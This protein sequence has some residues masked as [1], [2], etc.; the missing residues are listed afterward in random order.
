MKKLKR[1]NTDIELARALARDY[2]RL[3]KK[4]FSVRRKRRK[5]K[6]PETQEG[7]IVG[8]IE[9]EIKGYEN[10]QDVRL[11]RGLVL[12]PLPKLT[13]TKT[14]VGYEDARF[15]AENAMR[16]IYASTAASGTGFEADHPESVLLEVFFQ[17]RNGLIQADS[18]KILELLQYAQQVGKP[19]PTCSSHDWPMN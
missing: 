18:P 4:L 16:R 13:W 17:R 15:S 9:K 1:D 3:A 11:F 6:Q 8:P 2:P 12:E 5:R 14:L 10:K 19:K 7:I